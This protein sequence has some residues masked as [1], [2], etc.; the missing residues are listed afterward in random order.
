MN[1]MHPVS[2]MKSSGSEWFQ[3]L[4]RDKITSRWQGS[5]ESTS[6]FLGDVPWVWVERKLTSN[7]SSS[8]L[9]PNHANKGQGHICFAPLGCGF[10]HLGLIPNSLCLPLSTQPLLDSSSHAPKCGGGFSI[11]GISVSPCVYF[12]TILCRHPSPQ[13][14]LVPTN[15]HLV[16]VIEWSME[17]KLHMKQNYF[18][19]IRITI[20]QVLS[21]F[22]ARN[23]QYFP[24]IIRF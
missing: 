12:I 22:Q 3:W 4:G 18:N 16:P 15:T 14:L 19:G 24:K 21:V 2:W 1:R 5:V 13:P 8:H 10:S 9:L 7:S 6:C 17:E 23:Y 20:S 11:P